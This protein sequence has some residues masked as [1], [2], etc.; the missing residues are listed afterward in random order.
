MYVYRPYL[1]LSSP[2]LFGSNI[3]GVVVAGAVSLK[4][5]TFALLRARLYTTIVPP[6]PT[7]DECMFITPRQNMAAM[8]ASTAKP[9]LLRVHC[10]CRHTA[11]YPAVRTGSSN[12]RFFSGGGWGGGGWWGGWS[13]AP[14]LQFSLGQTKTSCRRSVN[15]SIIFSRLAS[16]R[17]NL[18]EKRCRNY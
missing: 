15:I 12:T 8:A 18:H 10:Q 6:P 13:L 17:L 14:D 3:F 9:F 16:I 4:S 5:I 7:P 11:C 2:V 1:D